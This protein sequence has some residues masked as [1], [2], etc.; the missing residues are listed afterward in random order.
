MIIAIFKHT[1]S[2]HFSK[3]STVKVGKVHV[4]MCC[5]LFILC[6]KYRSTEKHSIAK[7]PVT[8]E[9]ICRRIPDEILN[10]HIR[11]S[12]LDEIALDLVSWE[13]L[14]P[15]LYLTDADQ[16]EISQSFTHQ[17]YLQKRQALRKW[18]DKAGGKATLR[19]L[20]NVFVQE[21][22]VDLAER[23]MEIYQ[24]Q[25]TCFSVSK[26]YL[27]KHYTEDLPHPSEN[28]WPSLLGGFDIPP[29]Y[30]ELTLLKVPINENETTRTGS[31]NVKVLRVTDVFK[32]SPDR[33]VILIEGVAGSGKTTFSWYACREWAQGRLLQQFT[34]LIYV[35][36]KNPRFQNACK[37]HDLILEE[38]AEARDQIAQA[39]IDS[40]GEGVCFLIEGMDEAADK[41]SKGLWELILSKLLRDKNLSKLSFIIT[42][43]PSSRLLLDLEK[44]ITL[45]IAINGFND[46]KLNEF[47]D[48]IMAKGGDERSMLDDKFEIN[49]KL[50]ALCT[51]PINAAIASYLIKCFKELPTTQTELFYVLFC[52]ICIRHM[53]LRL[54][55]TEDLVIK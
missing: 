12:L 30:V 20:I 53:Q 48:A 25:P 43:R 49:H 37:L 15:S 2:L 41:A 27:C 14:A 24:M 4:L 38:N 47:L 36:V 40:K 45:R 18:R 44:T 17:Y 46:E 10:A 50:K 8:A 11:I 55:I 9:E 3:T 6:N 5:Y 26:K 31:S 23:I 54:G 16:N 22:V 42:S 28:Q 52:H 34:L 29:V 19:A 1:H 51:I 33:M 21:R 13:E 35:E 7:M 32:R 39:I